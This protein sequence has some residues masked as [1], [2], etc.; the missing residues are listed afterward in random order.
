MGGS[1]FLF[2]KNCEI[3]V[4]KCEKISIIVCNE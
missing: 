3:L 1:T 2:V 4:K